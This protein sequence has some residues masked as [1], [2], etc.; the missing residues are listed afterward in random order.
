LAVNV[1]QAWDAVES[2]FCP[3]LTIYTVK[4]EW[5]S[6]LLFLPAACGVLALTNLIGQGL[7]RRST[8]HQV[9]YLAML[10]DKLTHLFLSL[11][12]LITVY[13]LVYVLLVAFDP[14]N[15]LSA[16]PDFSNSNILYNSELLP[17]LSGLTFENFGKLFDGVTIPL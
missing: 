8:G 10:G 11:V 3:S 9:W 5:T 16:F 12:V 6:F 2:N 14:K 1:F 13:L 4:G 17:K 7:G 15:S